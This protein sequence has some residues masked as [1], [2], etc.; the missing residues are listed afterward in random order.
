MDV[1][2]YFS[3]LNLENHLSPTRKTGLNEMI[4]TIKQQAALLVEL[5]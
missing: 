4:K 3:Q 2:A 5:E 1:P